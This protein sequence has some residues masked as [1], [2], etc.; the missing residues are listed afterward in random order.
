MS[1]L[2]EFNQALASGAAELGIRL[3]DQQLHLFSLHYSLLLTH[4]THRL[5][6]I[7][8][9]AHAAIK[10][11]LDSLTALVLREIRP[12][13][14]VADIGSGAGFPGL[15]LAVARPHASYTLIESNLKRAAFLREAITYLGLTNVEVIADR[16]ET[17]ARDTVVPPLRERGGGKRACPERS[18]MG[19][20]PPPLQIHPERSRGAWR[21][22]QGVRTDGSAVR[23][24]PAEGGPN[25]RNLRNLRFPPSGR[26]AV[27]LVSSCLSGAAVRPSPTHRE[28][29]DLVIARAL[30]PLP[31]L[32]EYCLPLVRV[33]GDCLAL[34]GPGGEAELARSHH[35]LTTLGGHLTA[36]R[37]LP[38]P[39]GMGDR[40]L[41][42]VRKV[43]PTPDRYP[44]RPGVAAK[45]PL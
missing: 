1:S 19:G 42:L 7:T 6:T 35:A 14:R 28:S 25:P 26:F 24:S 16:A 4:R 8:D 2:A 38:L 5:T 21:G 13:E 40:F 11:F 15:V 39:G 33:G 17:L 44:R 9:P 23:P 22:G 30:A 3:T 27:P 20:V 12:G 36:T 31:V 10:H 45:R 32:L 41:I 43:S 29:Y 37:N 34:K 18:R